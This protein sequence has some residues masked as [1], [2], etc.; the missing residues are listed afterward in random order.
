MILFFFCFKLK[1]L[2]QDFPS[3]IW[4]TGWLVTNERDTLS[5]SIKYNFENASNI[6]VEI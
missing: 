4:H 5:G 1:L 6:T 3:E 2:S